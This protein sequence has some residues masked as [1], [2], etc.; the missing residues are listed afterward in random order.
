MAAMVWADIAFIAAVMI[1]PHN[2][3]N[4]YIPI[5]VPVGSFCEIS[6]GEMLYVADMGKMDVNETDV[7]KVDRNKSDVN[8]ADTNQA[9]RTRTQLS[10][11]E[12]LK[13]FLSLEIGIEIKACLYFSIIMFFY[14]CYRILTGSLEASIPLMVEIVLTAYAMSYLQV[15]LLQN[16]DEAERFGSGVIVRS[17][18]CTTLY[19]A[20]SYLLGWFDR[21]LTAAFAF[22]LYMKTFAAF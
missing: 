12:K 16:F 14:F 17:L 10:N 7:N 3:Q 9:D 19:T 13:K 15:Y 20:V 2:F 22:F 4:S 11:V 1:G 6:I 5:A 8:K 18:F 21:N